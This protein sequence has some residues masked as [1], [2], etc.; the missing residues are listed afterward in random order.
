MSNLTDIQLSIAKGLSYFKD[1]K[2]IE[3]AAMRYNS[4][5]IFTFVTEKGEYKYLKLEVGICNLT[6]DM[7]KLKFLIK[8]ENIK[9]RY[10]IVLNECDSYVEE[11]HFGDHVEP[12]FKFTR[13]NDD[14]NLGSSL[15]E[16]TEISFTKKYSILKER[17]GANITGYNQE[18]NNKLKMLLCNRIMSQEPGEYE[19][20]LEKDT[21]DIVISSDEA[22]IKLR[23]ASRILATVTKDKFEI[24]FANLIYF[25]YQI[26]DNKLIADLTATFI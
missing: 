4:L 14:L 20:V 5:I 16:L 23:D 25:G 12:T 24:P 26:P 11:I 18:Y 10:S 8:K 3:I 17:E 6:V 1:Y 2:L 9:V 7:K 21:L 19:V 13:F 15:I 22:V